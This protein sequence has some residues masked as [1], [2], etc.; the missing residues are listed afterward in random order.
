MSQA[1]EINREMPLE[2]II[3]D[4]EIKSIDM[5]KLLYLQLNNTMLIRP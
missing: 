3:E 1:L 2:S 4:L 5:A